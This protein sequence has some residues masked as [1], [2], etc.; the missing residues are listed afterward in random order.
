MKKYKIVWVTPD[1]FLDTDLDY[2]LMSGLLQ[3]YN[4]HWIVLFG[5]NNNRYTASDFDKLKRENPGLT[6]EFVYSRTRMRDPRQVI[7]FLR[8]AKMIFQ[9]RPDVIY[10]S[11]MP[12]SPYILP[13]WWLLPKKKTIF[14]AHDGEVHAGYNNRKL[15]EI[16]RSICYKF[17]CYVNM[18]SPN[19]KDKF[20]RHFPSAKIFQFLLALKDM[21]L[22]SNNRPVVDET[23]PI[24]FLSFGSISFGKHKDLLI[25]AAC[26]LYEQGYKNFMVSINGMCDNWDFYQKHI[27]YPEIFELNIR[28]IPNRD[29]PNLFNGCHFFVQ[30]YR[31]VTQSGPMKIAFRY[32]L[33][34]ICSDLPGFSECIEGVNGFKF[35]SE[36]VDDLVRVMKHCIDN[37]SKN[38]DI[39]LKHMKEYTDTH[40]S[41]SI[42]VKN[43]CNMFN[44]VLNQN[45]V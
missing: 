45:K 26:K 3:Q 13:L 36:D 38:Y 40:Y 22:P 27:K 18:F 6:I 30:P 14:V 31:I 44:E 7:L 43:Y 32:N 4:I 15:L 21:G 35:K 20:Q 16:I 8:I 25:D 19:E 2:N 5:V 12:S 34:D 37:Y 33:P 23:H 29:I 39:L 10:F 28:S 11:L 41:Y 24:R 9:S 1:C 42:V 17:A